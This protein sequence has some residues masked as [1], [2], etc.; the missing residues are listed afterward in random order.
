MISPKVNRNKR[1]NNNKKVSNLRPKLSQLQKI[2][3]SN[4][5]QQSIS[6]KKSQNKSVFVNWIH[7]MGNYLITKLLQIPNQSV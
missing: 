1:I 3:L 7:K 5:K 2:K 6:S 4:K